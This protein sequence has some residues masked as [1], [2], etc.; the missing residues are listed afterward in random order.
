VSPPPGKRVEI[1][2]T[3]KPCPST[4]DPS[5]V[6]G[7]GDTSA[8]GAQLPVCIE[9]VGFVPGVTFGRNVSPPSSDAEK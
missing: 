8:L 6:F 2:R 5:S 7:Y 1:I 9:H 3:L 4:D